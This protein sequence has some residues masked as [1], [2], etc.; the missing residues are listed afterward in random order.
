MS[1]FP[2]EEVKTMSIGEDVRVRCR[3]SRSGFS[4]ERV[5]RLE[6][7]N[8]TI[9]TGAAPLDYCF[10]QNHEPLGADQP[11][12]GKL[13][14]GFLSARVVRKEPDGT[15]WVHLPS[16]DVVQVK[17]SSVVRQHAEI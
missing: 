5:F 3:I 14:Q 1:R 2:D 12:V 6:L 7:A 10:N 17:Q 16:G 9:H 15:S 13:I 4:S 8:G 11:P